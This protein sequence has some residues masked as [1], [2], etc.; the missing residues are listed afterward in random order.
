MQGIMGV[1]LVIERHARIPLLHSGLNP[2][3][4][5]VYLILLVVALPFCMVCMQVASH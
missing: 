2:T 3:L 5:S 1:L 4:L